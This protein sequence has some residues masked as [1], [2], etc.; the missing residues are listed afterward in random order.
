MKTILV[1]TDFSLR[2][3]NAADYAMNIAIKNKANVILCHVMELTT[4]IPDNVD[5][6]WPVPHHLFL[7][8][9]CLNDIKDLS[10]SLENCIPRNA[11]FKPSI[12]FIS[13]FGRLSQVA[14]KV[15]EE[16]SVDLV[17][18][19]SHKSNMVSRFFYGSHT[20]TLLNKLFCPV[21]LVP[22]N[23]RFLGL[24]DIAYAT[25]L[26]FNNTRV[27]NYLME[28]ADPFK[29]RIAVNHISLLEFPD[30]ASDQVIALAIND[31]LGDKHPQVFYHDIKGAKV[32]KGLLEVLG[33]G[34]VDILVLVH[35]RYEFFEGL[36]HSSISMQMA[37]DAKVP[38]LVLPFSYS[39]DIADI[40]DEQ[41]DNFCYQTGDKR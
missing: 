16:Q 22:E 30:K 31:Q 6:N 11:D 18:I 41:L 13:E 39:I 19:G 7:K 5:F 15:I 8:N 34:R 38:L 12:S 35:K 21:L 29:A 32:K 37:D 23:L 10:K 9:E 17:V 36:L 24:S 2:A 20:H 26:T 27:I 25:D 14:D 28:F 3:R 40:S 33:S 4:P 1:L